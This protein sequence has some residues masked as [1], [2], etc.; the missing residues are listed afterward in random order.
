MSSG[1]P[2]SR[3][4][5][6]ALAMI[7][8]L[9]G[10]ASPAAPAAEPPVQQTPSSTPTAAVQAQETGLEQPAQ[11]FGGDCGLALPVA[12]VT[13]AFGSPMVAVANPD[14]TNRVLVD[15]AGGVSCNFR[16][17]DYG[18]NLVATI[19]PAGASVSAPVSCQDGTVN[20]DAGQ[21][22]TLTEVHDGIL[23]SALVSAPGKAGEA[24]AE[25]VMAEF[26]TTASP[27]QAAPVPIAADDAWV[28]PLDCAALAP[29]LALG[30]AY[31]N[32]AGYSGIAV[33]GSDAPTTPAERSLLNGQETMYCAFF[34][35]GSDGTVDQISVHGFGG[36][37]WAES[38]VRELA[39]ATVVEVDGL[40]SVIQSPWQQGRTRIDVF[41]GVNWIST[42][43]ARPGD[44][45]AALA[46]IIGELNAR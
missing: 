42:T 37:R 25:K 32:G 4:I 6:A 20:G 30:S 40:E 1:L 12:G 39:G 41:D 27:A 34:P 18:N 22:C 23:L 35:A 46:V 15:N 3:I 14:I 8:L 19:V 29:D 31:G 5:V 11:V 38:A 45:Y 10:C 16:S 28:W 7:V 13:A 26:T 36:A 2:G 43:S 44:D 17:A 33:G 24:I 9:T 21:T